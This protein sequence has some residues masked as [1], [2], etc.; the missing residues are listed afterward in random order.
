[1]KH[2]VLSLSIL[3]CCAVYVNAQNATLSDADKNTTFDSPKAKSALKFDQLTIDYGEIEKGSDP[4]RSFAFENT[5]DAPVAI[6]SAKGSCGCTVPE[7]PKEPIMP[8][9]K[10]VVKVRYDTERV[11]SFAK[12]VTLV[13]TTDETI[14][15]NIKGKVHR[16]E[17]KSVPKQDDAAF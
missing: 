17:N 5:S 13:T 2:I 4:Y 15:L 14:I 10:N 1:M 8:G 7:Y 11:G 3:L 16:V 9:E 12:T 6:K